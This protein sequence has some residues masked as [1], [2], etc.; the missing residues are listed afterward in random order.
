MDTPKAPWYTASDA[1]PLCPSK[2]HVFQFSW[3]IYQEPPLFVADTGTTDTRV[4]NY[5]TRA[6]EVTEASSR[7]VT[8]SRLRCHPGCSRYFSVG[9]KN[10]GLLWE[11]HDRHAEECSSRS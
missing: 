7:H 5:V 1:L 2:C 6:G 8:L 4:T 3:R 9:T 10:E 11:K